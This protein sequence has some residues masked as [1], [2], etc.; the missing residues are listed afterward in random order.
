MRRRTNKEEAQEAKVQK[1]IRRRLE[2][3]ETEEDEEEAKLT[4]IHKKSRT[5][6]VCVARSYTTKRRVTS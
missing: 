4:W 3:Q 2:A 6:L 5:R 1:K